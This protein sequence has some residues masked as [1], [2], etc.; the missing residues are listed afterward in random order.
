MN[1]IAQNWKSDDFW[2]SSLK[3]CEAFI[4][5]FCFEIIA[6]ISWTFNNTLYLQDGGFR[7]AHRHSGIPHYSCGTKL[8]Q[9]PWDTADS[10]DTGGSRIWG[11]PYIFYLQAECGMWPH[12]VLK[13]DTR[14]GQGHY[15]HVPLVFIEF[16]ASLSHI[17]DVT[18]KQ[19]FFY[20]IL[21]QNRN[22]GLI[23]ANI[24]CFSMSLGAKFTLDIFKEAKI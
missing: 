16:D 14:I 9:Q 13:S 1:R 24:T 7:E 20:W 4:F 12:K 10:R 23:P 2:T 8:P 6:L 17:Q 3:C 5:L 11:L 22:L 19:D 18:A 21:E 15:L